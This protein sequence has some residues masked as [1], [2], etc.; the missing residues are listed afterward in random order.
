MG[1]RLRGMPLSAGDRT[2]IAD[3]LVPVDCEMDSKNGDSSGIPAVST[4]GNLWP[5]HGSVAEVNRP[6]VTR[7]RKSCRRGRRKFPPQRPRLFEP[8]L[9][10][11][12]W[13]LGGVA[14]VP[15]N[16]SFLRERPDFQQLRVCIFFL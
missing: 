6:S 8:P 1:A 5:G 2:G 12:P 16:R 11:P 13:S 3:R 14:A 9:A 15:Y 4:E 10:G 7:A